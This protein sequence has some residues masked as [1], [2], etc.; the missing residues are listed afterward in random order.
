MSRRLAGRPNNLGASYHKSL[1]PQSRVCTLN[2]S[3]SRGEGCG[4]GTAGEGTQEAK[5]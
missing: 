1:V 3:K 5:H 2:S 4:V